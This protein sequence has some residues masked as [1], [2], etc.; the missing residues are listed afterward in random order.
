MKLSYQWLQEYLDLPEAPE[1]L[2]NLITTHVAEV[3]HV[4]RQADQ[5]NQIVVG[6]I[7]EVKPHP[8]AD[9]LRLCA[10][11]L[12]SE[13]SQIVCG[14]T[15]LVVGQYV[16]V[17]NPGA[18]VRWHGEGE[19]V[20]LTETKIRGEKSSGM[21]CAAVEL[22]LEQL[23]PAND[24]R[25]I[26][27]LGDPQQPV[28][29]PIAELLGM[30]DVTITIDNKTLT[31]RPDLFCHV[32]F[33]RELSVILDRPLKLPVFSELES[34]KTMPLTVKIDDVAQCRRYIGAAFANVE[35]KDSPEWLQR[36]L[37]VI[38]LRPINNVVDI[39]N[40][41]MYEYGQPLHA[42][43][44]DK[45]SDHIIRVRFAQADE[46]ITTLDGKSHQ[47]SEKI[48]VIADKTKPEAVAGIM[49]GAASEITATTT[50]VALE[51]ANFNPVTIRLGAQAL[52]IRTD[53]STRH[54]KNLSWH[55]PQY[56]F[57]RAAQL[58]QELAGATLASAITDSQPVAPVI[59]PIT[60][61]L[62]YVRR[63]SGVEFSLDTVTKLLTGLGC[64]VEPSTTAETVLVT[65]PGHRSDLHIREELVEE[66]ARLHGYDSVPVQPLTAPLEPQPQEPV[67]QLGNVIVNQLV[68]AGVDEVMAYS[69]Y[70]ET[71]A[72][73]AG[74]D[75]SAHLRMLNPM[76]PDQQLLRQTQLVNLRQ[77]AETNYQRRFKDFAL[78]EY[79]HVYL[80]DREEVRVAVFVVA[81]DDQAFYRA[82]GLAEMVLAAVSAA[83]KVSYTPSGQASYAVAGSTVATV[84]PQAWE[85]GSAA[86]V[87]ILLPDLLPVW[88]PTA[89]FVAPPSFPG[90]ELDIS[91][92]VAN[93]K[94]FA[95]IRQSIIR[96][97][98]GIIQDVTVFDVF[99]GKGVKPGQT[100]LGLRMFLQAFDRTLTMDEA[101]QLRNTVISE[102]TVKFGAQHRY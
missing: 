59:N 86:Y 51:S 91:I 7:V 25:E 22:G 39:T 47:L 43:D 57:L 17:A 69:F 48:L 14:G 38:G 34:T 78:V 37:R 76:N 73:V 5:F 31:H 56:G 92:A 35:V 93:D 45:M 2:A 33:A 81:A 102:L 74:L 23:F 54:E 13:T 96:A 83:Y 55:F 80:A 16:V 21:I 26:I 66:V 29:T 90:I 60:L 79:G 40:Y 95:E 32:G 61:E 8:N 11:E 28:G 82:K 53:G 71:A 36:R 84:T 94:R 52:G 41:V 88:N 98:K 75:V 27:D 62:A 77:M 101:E 24:E 20:E 65:P 9:K 6:K 4:E 15:N 19:L 12:G 63:L 44:Y 99:R 85:D 87:E 3:E 64:T 18:R 46:T 49:G 67:W 97:G 30:D 68:A 42:F 50:T 10:V 72:R 89:R 1:V 58:L 100:A 70:S